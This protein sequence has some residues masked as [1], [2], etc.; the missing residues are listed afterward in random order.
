MDDV[1]SDHSTFS[2][3]RDRL[4]VHDVI[5]SL[6]AAVDTVAAQRAVPAGR[7]RISTSAAFG[8]N[9]VLPA[10]PALLAI[11]ACRSRSTLMIGSSIL[12]ETATT[13]RSKA[14]TSQTRPL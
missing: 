12:S 8:H 11:P 7:V 9:H 1:V 14:G 6:F 3:N 10:L 13:L 2:K 4:M 5:V